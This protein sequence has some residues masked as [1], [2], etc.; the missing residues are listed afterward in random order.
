MKDAIKREKVKLVSVSEREHARPK[1]KA[2]VAIDSFKGCLTSKEANG[3][4]KL[5]E[6]WAC[7]DTVLPKWLVVI[8]P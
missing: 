3:F 5:K 4:S 1:V 8:S 2:V 6:P 7:F